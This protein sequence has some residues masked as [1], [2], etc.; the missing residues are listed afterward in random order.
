MTTRKAPALATATVSAPGHLEED[1][2][3]FDDAPEFMDSAPLDDMDHK[4]KA[5]QEQYFAMLPKREEAKKN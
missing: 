1:L 4:V 3:R 5:A 2:L